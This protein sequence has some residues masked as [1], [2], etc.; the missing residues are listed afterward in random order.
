MERVRKTYEEDKEFVKVP[1][2]ASLYLTLGQKA[3]LVLEDYEGHVVT[4]ESDRE[5]EKAIKL[6]LSEEKAEK[7]ISK[8]GDRPYRIKEFKSFIDEGVSLPL[9]ELNKI[10][11]QAVEEISEKRIFIKRELKAEDEA[12]F[13]LDGEVLPQKEDNLKVNVSCKNIEQLKELV[14]KNIDT[15]Y[16]R[17]V[18]SLNEAIE[19]AKEN[20]KKIAFYMPRIIRSKENNI[21]KAL[22]SI[23]KENME[24]MDSFRISNYG[25]IERVKK[26]Y[27]SKKIKISPWMNIIND[28]AIKYYNSIKADTICLS[29]EVSMMQIRNI[30]DEVKKENNLEYLVYGHTEMMVS[31]YCP[32]G[33]LI[34]DCK[35]NKRD[36]S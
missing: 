6:A 13:K 35:K 21:Y 7:Q 15:I 23:G 1:L 24:Y 36:A 20:S 26:I 16:Y 32:M 19:M 12:G 22:S 4:S 25:E 2:K 28:E 5:V 30:S 18:Y 9:S 31:E 17:D 3:K 14:K 10:R 27:P 11:R 34:K 33:V 8:M 29:Q